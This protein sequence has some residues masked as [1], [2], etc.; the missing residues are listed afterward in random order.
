MS[1]AHRKAAGSPSESCGGAAKE[2]WPAL[3]FCAD[4]HAV[5]DR[6]VVS[7]GFAH[8]DDSVPKKLTI[9]V[10][11]IAAIAGKNSG[12]TRQPM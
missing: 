4:D 9:P 2:F 3:V 11:H 1:D 8:D 6:G 7:E 12:N 10:H 5:C